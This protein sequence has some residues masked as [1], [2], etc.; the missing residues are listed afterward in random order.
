M[1]MNELIITAKQIICAVL[2]LIFPLLGI[3][4]SE[5]G[6]K[7]NT[8]REIVRVMS[9]NVRYTELERGEI[10]PQVVAD[11]FPDSVGLQECSGTWYLTMMAYLSDNY[12]IVGVGRDTGIPLLGESTAIMFRKDKYKLVDWG[13]FW[14]SETPD[15]ISIGWDA[16]H[17]R[18]C[19]WVILQNRDTGEQY[20]HINT[21]LDHV[22]EIAR[23]KGVEMILEKVS[24]FDMP[25]VVTGDFNFDSTSDSYNFLTNGELSDVSKLAENA[26]SGC[27]MHD[28]TGRTEGTPIDFICVNEQIS[29][30]K[31][32]KIIRDTYDGQ[33]V[34][35]HYP[36]CADVIF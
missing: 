17:Y 35:D 25:V 6:A 30:V 21:H 18:T 11:Y 14:L 28:Y 20:A 23:E 4:R 5:V 1:G 16:K 27:T 12:E 32:Y 3:G 10:V 29:S 19:T 36:I 31:T 34:S 24:T 15:K 8:D 22:G 7:A 13:T 9:F 26:D 33:Y 2:A